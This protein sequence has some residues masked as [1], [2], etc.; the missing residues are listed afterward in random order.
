MLASGIYDKVRNDSRFQ[1]GLQRIKAE[2][3]ER[4]QRARRNAES[5]R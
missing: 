4:V 5:K 2:V 1:A 3:Y